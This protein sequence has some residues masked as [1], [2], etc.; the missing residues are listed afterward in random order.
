MTLK[1][2]KKFGTLRRTFK[3]KGAIS[4]SNGNELPT[5]FSLAQR[6]DGQLLLSADV[7]LS[8]WEFLADKLEVQSLTGIL[9]DGRSATISGP[10]FLKAAD[11]IPRTNKARL[12]A[13][14]S[15]WTFGNTSLTEPASI[16]FELVN[17][18]FLG[19]KSEVVSQ[20]DSKR[21]PLSLMPLTLENRDL[22]LRWVSDYD[23]VEAALQAR[24]GVEVTCIATATLNS[25]EEL[26]DVVSTLTMLD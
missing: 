20:D 21:K 9:Q 16:T 2:L 14:P 17:F 15:N 11:P 26:S 1:S 19:T 5:R 13:Y 10:I 24:R 8:T 23:Q 7:N 3:G 22:Q 18:R 4:L 25:F 6:S 12:I